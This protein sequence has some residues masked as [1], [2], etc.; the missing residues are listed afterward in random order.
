MLTISNATK[1]QV[2]ALVNAVLGLLGAF[3]IGSMTDAQKGAIIVTANAF[4][5]V[6][7]GVTYK[8]SAKRAPD[9]PKVP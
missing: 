6:V 1:A 5:A 8:Q 2:I 4:L 9:P 7:V 3:N